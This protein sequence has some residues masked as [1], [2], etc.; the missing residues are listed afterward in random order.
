MQR[1]AREGKN[2]DMS[3]NAYLVNP[4]DNCTHEHMMRLLRDFMKTTGTDSDWYTCFRKAAFL[5]QDSAAF[6]RTRQDGLELKDSERRALK[7]EDPATGSR[8]DQPFILY[9]MVACCSLSAAVQGDHSRQLTRC[10]LTQCFES[11]HGS[12]ESLIEDIPFPL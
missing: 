12:G 1:F 3:V 9:A 5:A 4:F 11:R 10:K 8:W 6:V 7:N 2:S